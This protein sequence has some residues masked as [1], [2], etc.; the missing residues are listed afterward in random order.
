MIMHGGKQGPGEGRAASLAWQ[1]RWCGLF[2]A[3]VG[4]LQSVGGCTACPGAI[5]PAPCMDRHRC[6]N[7]ASQGGR[8][9][10]RRDAASGSLLPSRRRMVAPSAMVLILLVAASGGCGLPRSA[11]SGA[12][13][14]R[15]VASPST[16][17]VPAGRAAPLQTDR[18]VANPGLGAVRV[19]RAS[20]AFTPGSPGRTGCLPSVKSRR[21]PGPHTARFRY[22]S[23][24]SQVD[25]VIAQP[26]WP[27]VHIEV[28]DP[29]IPDRPSPGQG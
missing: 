12:W 13:M 23:C 17:P 28:I 24:H 6:S 29:A 20:R 1:P 21:C 9:C 18:T 11:Q 10:L 4:L 8:P 15:S 2:R 26:S 5:W 16:A 19:R 7:W 22:R 3:P 27:H 25:D 14:S